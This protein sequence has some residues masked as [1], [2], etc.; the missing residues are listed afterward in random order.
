MN[1]HA[2]PIEMEQDKI[3][4]IIVINTDAATI[5]SSQFTSFNCTI[6]KIPI[7]TNDDAVTDAVNNDNTKGAKNIDKKCEKGIDK[8]KFGDIILYATFCENRVK[9]LHED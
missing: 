1:P 2:M 5:L 9:V 4:M 8:K 6:I 3:I 7:M